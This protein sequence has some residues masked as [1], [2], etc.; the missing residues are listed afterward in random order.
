MLVHVDDFYIWAKYDTRLEF[1]KFIQSK[2]TCRVTSFITI[3]L[4]GE[5][6]GEEK[7]RS[8][9]GVITAPNNKHVDECCKLLGIGVDETSETPS[10]VSDAKLPNATEAIGEDEHALYGTCVGILIYYCRRRA[11][12]RF[13]VKTLA[14]Y[15][16]EPNV[17][18]ITTLTRCVKYL[19][20]TR[21]MVQISRVLGDADRVH[22]MSDS[23]WGGSTLDRRSTAGSAAMLAG[24]SL[25]EISRSNA[26][27]SLSSAEAEL[28]ALIQT[29]VI[30]LFC[31]SLL[32]ELG[33]KL[34]KPKLWTDA[35]AAKGA[36]TREGIGRMKHIDIRFQ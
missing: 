14:K 21:D 30:C 10:L 13:T 15:I 17:Y 25:A 28:Y 1:R 33:M 34:A 8:S 31:H 29:A 26:T 16:R 20:G 4:W 12:I 22:G 2:V 24:M 5:Y 9:D 7:Y 3:G 23:D 6:L 11:D 32:R 36:V 19:N 18:A 27:S 35:E